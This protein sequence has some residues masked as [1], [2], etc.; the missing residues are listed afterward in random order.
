MSVVHE[1]D[2]GWVEHRHDEG[3]AARRK[4]LGAAAGGEQIGCS[5]IELP[6]GKRAWPR[7][8][9]SANEEAVVV[10]SGEGV[11]RLGDREL[12]LRAGCYAALPA[13]TGDA[14]QVVNTS[15]QP[16]RYLCI[17]TMRHPEVVTYPDSGKVGVITGSAPGGD[18]D[19]RTLT[20]F[21]PADAAVDYW[22]GE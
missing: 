2:L 21:L 8:A 20:A 4:Q 19:A 1:G 12:P 5:L 7:H 15:E 14:H 17:S 10:L 3:F 18:N 6:P 9:H 13:G 11:L 22:Q 16:L